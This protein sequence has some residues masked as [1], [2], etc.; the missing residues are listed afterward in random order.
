MSTQPRSRSQSR[1]TGSVHR[2]RQ[3]QNQPPWP[4]VVV[5]VVVL[6][7]AVVA[8]L[9]SRGDD[10]PQT[11]AGVEQTR[12]VQVSGSA[13]P[14]LPDTGADP[15]VGRAAPEVRGQGFDGTSV[16][17]TSDGKPKLVLFVAHWCP[18]CQRE[19]P[20]LSQYLATQTLPAPVELIT[21]AT[22]T[23]PDRPNFPP[24]LWL[25]RENWPG[26]VLVDD[27]QGTTAQQFGLPSYPY[28]VAIDAEGK[29]V[30]RTTGEISTDAFVDLARQA[31]G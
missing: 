26:P 23:N 13:L 27:A 17:I 31:A 15:A 3:Q 7:A 5:A 12:P 21:V 18:H 10:Q 4:W 14:E 1:S 28:F 2:A 29:V 16:D 24:S 9:A 25:E 11:A 22:G 30:A 8:V 20:V 6:A 19:V